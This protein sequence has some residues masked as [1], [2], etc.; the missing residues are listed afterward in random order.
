MLVLLSHLKMFRLM[1]DLVSRLMGKP[2]LKSAKS[3][4]GRVNTRCHSVSGTEPKF[5]GLWQ[6]LQSCRD[7]PSTMGMVWHW[8]RAGRGWIPAREYVRAGGELQ[9]FWGTVPLLRHTEDQLG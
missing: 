4:V 1:S 3:R 6:G 5:R 8:D 2:G 9:A 7:L